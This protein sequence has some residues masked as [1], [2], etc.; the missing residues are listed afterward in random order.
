MHPSFDNSLP[1]WLHQMF[2]ED[3][4]LMRALKVNY[5]ELE[6]AP[7]N[8]Y[9]NFA[10]I[11]DKTSFHGYYIGEVNENNEP[12]GVGAFVSQYS[13]FFYFGS[14]VN[15]HRFGYGLELRRSHSYIGEFANNIFEGYGTLTP[16]DQLNESLSNKDQYEGYF[17]KG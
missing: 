14:W 10:V 4:D 12:H 15:N 1:T 5:V 9:L 11:V 13:D 7:I 8:A 17:Y 6:N 2:P 16:R 3:D